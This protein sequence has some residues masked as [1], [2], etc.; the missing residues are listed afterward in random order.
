MAA[1]YCIGAK[2][3]CGKPTGLWPRCS[4]LGVVLLPGYF[5]LSLFCGNLGQTAFSSKQHRPG[6]TFHLVSVPWSFC[7]C[8]KCLGTEKSLTTAWEFP[9]CPS[10]CRLYKGTSPFCIF[11]AMLGEVCVL[12]FL[13]KGTVCFPGLFTQVSPFCLWLQM[14]PWVG[15]F[16]ASME[17]M[18]SFCLLSQLFYLGRAAFFFFKKVLSLA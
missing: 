13:E 10:L 15:D 6:S 11:R 12:A 7:E 16:P 8:A 1:V 2:E 4:D 9:S 3:G 18:L 5:L 17:V 14:R